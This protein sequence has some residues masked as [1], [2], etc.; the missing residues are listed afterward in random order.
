MKWRLL[1]IRPAWALPA[2]CALALGACG[3]DPP[4]TPT[5]QQAQSQDKPIRIGT[6]NFTEQHILGELYA[7]ALRVEGFQVVLERDIGA[8]EIVHQALLGGGIDLYPEYIGVLLSEVA[9][10]TERPADAE[11][12]YRLAKQF[13]ERRGLTLLAPTP[14]S[15]QNAIAVL[16]TTAQRE[17]VRALGDL[18]L[19]GDEVTVG[20]PPEF[21]SRF[22]GLE[23]LETVYGLE[24]LQVEAMGIGSQYD[25]LDD[26]QVDAA[27]VFTTDGRLAEGD[28]VVLDDPRGLFASQHVAPVVSQEV[29]EASGPR[30]AETLDALN[31]RLTTRVMREMNA[32]VDLRGRE[33]ADVA[34][35]FLRDGAAG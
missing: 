3:G 14:F 32:E 34:A 29:L 22:E 16:P 6:K 10:V 26:G 18:E 5:T 24:N 30:V 2:L 19:L 11:A 28:Y 23:G 13:E 27:A 1:A 33:P 7:Q 21:A 25:A 35:K 12:A 4:T 15:D 9:G 31:A 8:S 20:A 17:G